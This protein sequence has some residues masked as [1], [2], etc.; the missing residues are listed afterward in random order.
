MRLANEPLGAAWSWQWVA[1]GAALVATAVIM[2]VMMTGL[3]TRLSREPEVPVPPT[4][5]ATIAIESPP[6]QVAALT[7]TPAM[8]LAVRP[9]GRSRQAAGIPVHAVVRVQSAQLTALR[10]LSEHI[11]EGRIDGSM[12]DTASDSNRRLGPIDPIEI[13]PIT[14]EPLQSIDTL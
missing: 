10:A 12:L 8:K 7:P 5:V 9:A 1:S 4:S 11:R 13:E 2:T 14:L 6:A 3:I